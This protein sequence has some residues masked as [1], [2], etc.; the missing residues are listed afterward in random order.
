M[1]SLYCGGYG[2]INAPTETLNKAGLAAKV[3]SI[4]M[5]YDFILCYNNVN[6]RTWQILDN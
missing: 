5:T 2:Q 4:G 6:N 1:I 3:I